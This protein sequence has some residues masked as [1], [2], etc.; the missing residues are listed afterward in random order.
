MTRAGLYHTIQVKIDNLARWMQNQNNN[1]YKFFLYIDSYPLKAIRGRPV[2]PAAAACCSTSNALPTRLQKAWRKILSRPKSCPSNARCRSL[3]PMTT[4]QPR[5]RPRRLGGG[6]FPLV[7]INPFW[8]K[9][10]A[11]FLIAAF[12][13]FVL[14]RDQERHAARRRPAAHGGQ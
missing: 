2:S 4:R 3:S 8:S 5:R 11:V 7:D 12:V 14:F 6:Q 9:I 10:F 13:A 1:P